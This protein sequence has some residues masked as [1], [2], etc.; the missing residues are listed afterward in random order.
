MNTSY[1]F[2]LIMMDKLSMTQDST[3]SP[4]ILPVSRPSV[5][6]NEEILVIEFDL[7]LNQIGTG[8]LDIAG[9]NRCSLSGTPR[10]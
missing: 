8:E 10:E 4:S 7:N 1:N 2:N 5:V 6:L 3:P 9:C